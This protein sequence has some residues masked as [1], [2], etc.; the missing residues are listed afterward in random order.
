MDNEITFLGLFLTIIYKCFPDEDKIYIDGFFN[1]FS[2]TALTPLA[3]TGFGKDRLS[4]TGTK[5]HEIIFPT[6]LYG[7]MICSKDLYN[8]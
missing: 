8:T 2:S 5:S 6:F 4:V 1:K 3:G 7:G